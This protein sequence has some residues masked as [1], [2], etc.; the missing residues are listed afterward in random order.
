VLVSP[1]VALLLGWLLWLVGER[2]GAEA[3]WQ[4]VGL[5]ALLVASLLV[6]EFAHALTAR[7][8]GLTVHD[9]IIG[10][11]GGMAR[12]QGLSQNPHAE[13]WV[14]AAGPLA[15][16][17]LA[18]LFW[19]VPGPVGTAGCAINLVF[20]IGNLLPAFPLDGGRILRSWLARSSPIVDATRAAIAFSHWMLLLLLGVAGWYGSFWLALLLCGFLF[21]SGREEQLA[22]LLRAGTSSTLSPRE[23]FARAW[24]RPR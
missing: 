24:S 17:C 5:L 22:T 19:A 12:M 18:L 3:T 10:P 15:N 13:G 2:A 9:V 23:V 4:V 20:G 7:R 21:W 1:L 14:A 11:L 6:H 8:L 16:L